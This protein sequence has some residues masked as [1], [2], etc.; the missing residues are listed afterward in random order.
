MFSQAEKLTTIWL[1]TTLSNTK[2]APSL[3]TACGV[4]LSRH[5]GFENELLSQI[6]GGSDFVNESFVQQLS[7]IRIGTR[8]VQLG[9]FSSWSIK[10][11]QS[12]PTQLFSTFTFKKSNSFELKL[13]T[14]P[15]KQTSK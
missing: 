13:N 9:E 3:R 2:V 11:K 7:S 10:T 1:G 8:P 6:Y 14:R 4:T 15:K 5:E 12:D